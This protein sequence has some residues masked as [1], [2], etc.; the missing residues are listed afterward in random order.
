MITQLP[1][2]D[3]PLGERIPRLVD[4]ALAG[5]TDDELDVD[6]QVALSVAGLSSSPPGP[7]TPR[8]SQPA[9]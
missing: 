1:E 2:S 4:L 5:C 3:I 9:Q 7:A 6:V 8:P